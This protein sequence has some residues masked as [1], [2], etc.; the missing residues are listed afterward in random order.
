MSVVDAPGVEAGREVG[1]GSLSC[2][3]GWSVGE[4]VAL[5]VLASGCRLARV[6]V[7]GPIGA[8]AGALRV[9]SIW[10]KSVRR[11]GLAEH[12]P[13]FS[14]MDEL[15]DRTIGIDVAGQ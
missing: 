11:R 5:A 13:I 4:L 6:D 9:R 7:A 8:S 15:S 3:S 14:G 1:R 2:C 10:L 12:R